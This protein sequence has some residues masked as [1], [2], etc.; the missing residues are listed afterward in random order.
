[1]GVETG[2][3]GVK[4][5]G[6]DAAVVEDQE[7]ARL[8]KMGEI[9]EKIVLVSAGGAVDR[10]HATRASNRRWG[11]GDQLFGKVEIEIGYAQIR[12]KMRGNLWCFGW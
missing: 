12:S 3:G 4:A 11:L 8:Q 5:S 6:D 1:M 7:V 9:A 10:E 2:A